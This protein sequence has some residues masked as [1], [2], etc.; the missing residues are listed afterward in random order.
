MFA[1]KKQNCKI[2]EAKSIELKEETDKCTIIFGEFNRTSLVAQTVKCLSINVGDLGSIP[3]SGRFPGEGNEPTPVL[4]PRKSHEQ[5]S[6]VQ[7]TVHGVTKSRT[8]LSDFT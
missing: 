3:G 4:L 6:L 2:Y 1:P 7:A 5:R 8:R